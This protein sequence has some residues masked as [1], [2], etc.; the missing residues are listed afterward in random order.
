VRDDQEGAGMSSRTRKPT[1]LLALLVLN[2][3]LLLILSGDDI[4][5]KKFGQV[6]EFFIL[7]WWLPFDAGAG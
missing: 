5:T 7:G 2:S 6:E 1:T 4:G 3:L